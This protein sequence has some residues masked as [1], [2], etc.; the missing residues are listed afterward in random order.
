MDR[1]LSELVLRFIPTEGVG[2]TNAELRTLVKLTVA[3]IGYYALR[4]EGA[5]AKVEKLRRKNWGLFVAVESANP[6]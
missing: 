1:E 4:A 5:E 3:K 6:N 2:M